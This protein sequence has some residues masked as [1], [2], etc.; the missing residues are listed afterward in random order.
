MRTNRSLLAQVLLDD[1]ER[2]CAVGAAARERALAWGEAAFAAELLRLL[3]TC[4]SD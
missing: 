1:E 2:L 4:C 3:Q